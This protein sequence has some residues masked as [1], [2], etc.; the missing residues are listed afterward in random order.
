V[1]V[2]AVFYATAK[3]RHRSAD[4]GDAV[5]AI[6][7]YAG[8]AL[9]L[10]GL[11]LLVWI[12]LLGDLFFFL[13]LASAGGGLA[14]AVIGILFGYLAL[15]WAMM[16][17]YHLPL[18]AAY[19][20]PASEIRLWSVVRD[21]FVLLGGSPGFTACVFLVIIALACLCAIPALVGTALIFPGT[22]A[23]LAVFALHEL[24]IR[25]GIVKEDDETVEDKPWK[26]PDGE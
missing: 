3:A 23:F 2:G 25:F 20:R 21:S 16:T 9:R 13:R 26:L 18:I 24:F 6:R 1:L 19:E 15:M 12:V 14:Y 11:G 8:T 10:Y 22:A 7:D 17:V 5:R 4:V